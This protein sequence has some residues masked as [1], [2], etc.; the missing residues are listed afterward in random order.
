MR[1]THCGLI[2]PWNSCDI[3]VMQLWGLVENKLRSPHLPSKS[4][5]HNCYQQKSVCMPTKECQ[6]P[7]QSQ[8][9]HIRPSE[10]L[11]CTVLYFEWVAN[12][13]PQCQPMCHQHLSMGIYG[14]HCHQPQWGMNP[15]SIFTATI[16]PLFFHLI[17]MISKQSGWHF[18]DNISKG[19][20]FNTIFWNASKIW[21][22]NIC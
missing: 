9:Y 1:I 18:A 3:T 10:L 12:K 11:W 6:T 21:L 17:I 14:K 7:C 16:H 4:A 22:K 8:G 5:W 19:M 13:P 20:F 15:S 2:I